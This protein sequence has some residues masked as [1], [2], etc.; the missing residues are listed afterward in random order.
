MEIKEGLKIDNPNVSIAWDID[1]QGLKGALGDNVHMVTD[2]Y[3]VAKRCKLLGGLECNIGFH[4]GKKH[5]ESFEFFRDPFDP[6]DAHNIIRKSFDEF[7]MYFE[8]EFGNATYT[9]PG[10]EEFTDYLWD[11][12]DFVIFHM[13]F[14]R[15]GLEEHVEIHTREHYQLSFG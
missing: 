12:G 1:E 4:F 7:Q 5:M 13:V 9:K 3:Y 15:Y 8:K 6:N 14:N 2:R 11:I 10:I